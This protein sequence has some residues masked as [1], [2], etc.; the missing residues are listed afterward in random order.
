M[1]LKT[2]SGWGVRG[3]FVPV[4]LKK[5]VGRTGGVEAFMY[6]SKTGTNKNGPPSKT[7]GGKRY[8]RFVSSGKRTIKE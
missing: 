1:N 5:Q 6:L 4:K 2:G 8:S 7:E 3:Q